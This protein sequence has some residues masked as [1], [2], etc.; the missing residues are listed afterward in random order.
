MVPQAHNIGPKRQQVKDKMIMS[1]SWPKESQHILLLKAHDPTDVLL[2]KAHSPT[3]A[4]LERSTTQPICR[5]PMHASPYF[6]QR[7]NHSAY[8]SLGRSSI[9]Y[10]TWRVDNQ[11][12]R[13]PID[14]PSYTVLEFFIVQMNRRKVFGY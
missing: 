9:S 2:L 8:S 13:T 6:I 7:L 11:L 4:L 14:H 5:S 3:D 10:F 12:I 1:T